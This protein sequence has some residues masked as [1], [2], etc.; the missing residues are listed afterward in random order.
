MRKCVENITNV[1]VPQLKGTLRKVSPPVWRRIHIRSDATLESLHRCIQVV[2]GWA[3]SHMHSFRIETKVYGPV[4]LGD[5]VESTDERKARVRDLFNGPGK[6]ALYEYDFGDGWA[7]QVLFECT[8]PFVFDQPYPWL[9]AGRR[10]CPP[11]DVGGPLGYERF[12]AVMSN[13][14]HPEHKELITWHGG[15][16]DAMAFDATALNLALHGEW[17][18]ATKRLTT[19]STRRT[20]ASRGLQGKPRATGRAR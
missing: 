8:V 15:P 1:N 2:F 9:L 5:I 18:P 7:H 16:F 19:R 10:A 3:D 4:A 11:D 6:C 12:L 13:P 17:A 20:P 14:R